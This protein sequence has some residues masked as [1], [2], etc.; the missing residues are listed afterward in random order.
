MTNYKA[1]NNKNNKKKTKKGRFAKVR[2]F[3]RKK[4]QKIKNMFKKKSK[5]MTS[6]TRR[7]LN[8]GAQMRERLIREIN[9]PLHSFNN[10]LHP[11]S[12]IYSSTPTHTNKITA[13]GLNNYSNYP[14]PK[15]SLKIRLLPKKKKKNL[16]KRMTNKL[17]LKKSRNY[18]KQNLN[19]LSKQI[20]QY[21]QTIR[22]AEYARK[23]ANNINRQQQIN[24]LGPAI[25]KPIG[26]TQLLP[27]SKTSPLNSVLPIKPL[28]PPSRKSNRST[29]KSKARNTAIKQKINYK[30]PK[31]LSPGKT[32][33]P[34]RTYVDLL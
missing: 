14:S 10:P 28:R 31:L 24:P 6:A 20:D 4:L 16:L 21:A 18:N 9:K 29:K 3:T 23:V 15:S 25:A 19:N 34:G 17:L 12:V 30:T 22:N 5:P 2:S 13:M 11:M 33:P 27:P 32:P 7:E 26:F 1:L 8:R